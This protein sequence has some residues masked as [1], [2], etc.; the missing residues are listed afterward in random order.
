MLYPATGLAS[1]ISLLFVVS[2]AIEVSA[3]DEPSKSGKT[4]GALLDL[5]S[6]VVFPPCKSI[7][8]IKKPPYNAKGDG[9]TDDTTAIQ[10]ALSDMMGQHQMLY[11][12]AGDYVVSSTLQWSNRNSSGADAWKGAM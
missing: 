4:V 12:P 11:F 3:G 1:L 6:D 9:K 8:N 7:I 2:F 5:K 10:K